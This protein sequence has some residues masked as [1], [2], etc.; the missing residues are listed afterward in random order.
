MPES[1]IKFLKTREV[2]TPSRG[3]PTDAGID[4]YVP[5]FTSSFLKDL[6]EKNPDIFEKRDITNTFCIT[7]SH[8]GSICISSGSENP[9]LEY[10]LKDK[11][12]SLIKFDEENGKQYFLLKMNLF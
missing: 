12:D 9:T 4:F 8:S 10:D 3:Y 11:N 1:T 2:K 6:K 5:K 7:N